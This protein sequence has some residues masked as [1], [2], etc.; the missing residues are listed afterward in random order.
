MD[1]V[2]S[3]AT[4]F[5]FA[6]FANHHNYLVRMA[7]WGWRMANRWCISVRAFFHAN[8]HHSTVCA[9]DFHV[10]FIQTTRLFIYF[11]SI[12]Y[13]ILNSIR[14]EPKVANE[15]EDRHI[16]SSPITSISIVSIRSINLSVKTHRMR[17]SVWRSFFTLN[18]N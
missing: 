10:R 6:L 9:I 11:R 4:S 13:F 5:F 17:N 15:F 3:I 12:V 14:P 2:Y 18:L 1:N 16:W 7:V 8:T